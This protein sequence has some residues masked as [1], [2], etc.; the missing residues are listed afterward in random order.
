MTVSKHENH[1]LDQDY[2]E[3]TFPGGRLVV[4]FSD[5]P[6]TLTLYKGEAEA[7][8]HCFHVDKPDETSKKKYVATFHRVEHQVIQ[9]DIEASN[10]DEAIDMANDMHESG[11]ISFA[12]ADVS[13]ADES[14]FSVEPDSQEEEE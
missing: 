10:Y 8:A 6:A 3:I 5:N 1:I 9:Y 14:L 4:D 11:K 12:F 7:L 13:H 2:H